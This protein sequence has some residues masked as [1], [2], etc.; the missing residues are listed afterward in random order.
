M[1]TG[2]NRFRS[3]LPLV[4]A[5]LQ[6]P[7]QRPATIERDRLLRPL[8]AASGPRVVAVIAPPGYGK[9]TLLAQW[10][11]RESRPVAWVTLDDLDN[12]PAVLLSYLATAFDRIEGVDDAIRSGLGATP[13]RILA[14]AVP[15]LLAE[16]ARWSRPAVLVLDDAHRLVEPTALDVVTSL[17]DHLP[18]G[19]RVAITARTEPALPLARL[20]AAGELLEIGSGQLALT[21][22]E[23]A[24]A[25]AADGHPLKPGDVRAVRERTEGWAA[26]IHLAALA[27]ARGDDEAAPADAL[28]GRDR[29]IAGYLRSEFQRDLEPDD[30]A[31]VTRTAI[32][33]TITPPLAEAITSVEDAWSRLALVARRNLLVQDVGGAGPALRYHN[34][35]RDFLLGELDEREPGARPELHRRAAIAYA[36][37]YDLERAV[38]HAFAS[39]DLDAVAAHV[40]AALLPTFF[41]GHPATV[42]RWV[43][44]LDETAFQRHPPLAVLAAWI[45]LLNGRPDAADRLADIAERSA[46]AGSPGDGSASFESQRAMLRAMMARHGPADVLASAEVAAAI[47]VADSP[48]RGTAL[49]V[50]GGGHRM[51]GR[52]AEAEAAFIAG[53]AAGNMVSAA[54]A[55]GLALQ[56]GDWAAAEP[57]IA[58]ARA[59]MAATHFEGLLQS[60]VVHAVGARVALHRGDQ[61]GAREDLVN[62][63]RVRPLASHAAPWLIV[64]ALLHLARAYLALGDTPGAQ[65]VLREAEA[66][67]RRRPGL[68]VL[69]TE[70]VELRRLLAHAAATLAGS[71]SL[72]AAELRLLPL[73]PTYLSFQEIADR[74]FVSR[75]TVKTQAMSIYGKLQASSRG[76][77]VERAVELGLLEPYPGLDPARRSTRD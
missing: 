8:L 69:T 63:Q 77:A 46:F 26:G 36:R 73:L 18:T 43:L 55:A 51:L 47:E 71:S 20:R 39:E 12:D 14:V 62:A 56:R 67:V 5:K 53:A 34:L 59:M 10:A 75:N 1:T 64:D 48:W 32:L 44:R 3:S 15:R 37:T 9:T 45:H 31:V 68:G 49:G 54:F 22:E 11:A 6:P 65:V 35:L 19:F 58:R 38:D 13:G 50:L 29:Y 42:D 27:L 66:I 24:V 30:V 16:L 23:T 52:P 2:T 7:A 57:M 17:L 4:E 60:I 74:L 28:S 33:E 72:T 76:E 25:V 41:G 40:A 21:D 61:A 70:L